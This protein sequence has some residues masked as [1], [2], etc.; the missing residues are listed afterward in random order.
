[1]TKATAKRGA[2][3][4]VGPGELGGYVGEAAQGGHMWLSLCLS[5]ST[6]FSRSILGH[7]LLSKGEKTK[8][9]NEKEKDFKPDAHLTSRQ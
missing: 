8:E 7:F 5:D 1:M 3:D 9:L 2:E 6:V 4:T